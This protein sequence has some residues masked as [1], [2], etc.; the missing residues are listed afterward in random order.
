MAKHE[1][2]S[3]PNEYRETL[4]R[5]PQLANA[6]IRVNIHQEIEKLKSASALQQ[7]TGRSSETLV[8]YEDFRIVRS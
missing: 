2:A 5:L 6:V 1:E 8:K 3:H 7:D 4:T